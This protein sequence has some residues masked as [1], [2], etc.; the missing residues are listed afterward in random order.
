MST[1]N[2]PS[3]C[4]FETQAIRTQISRSSFNEHTTPLYLT[5]SFVF[6]HAEEMRAVFAEDV[7]KFSYTRFTHPNQTELV[8]KM[9]LLEKAEAGYTFSTGMAAIFGSIF[10][11]IKPGNHIV[12]CLNIFGSSRTIFSSI[13]P[14]WGV[15]TS[16]FNADSIDKLEDLIQPNTKILFVETPTNPSVDVLDLAYLGKIARKY[17][18]IFVVDNTFATPYLQNPIDFGADVVVHSTTKL[19]DGQ[20]RVCGGI[21]VGKT[22]L[23]QKIYL[24]SRTIGSSISAFDAWILS[25]S[26]ETL[27]VRVDRHCENALKVA[28]FLENH[29]KIESVRYPFLPSHP[30]FDIATKQMKA[31]GNIIAFKLK[32]D[33]QSA[34]NFIDNVKLFSRTANLG[35]SRTI[36]THPTTTTHAR[37]PQDEKLQTGI[38]DNLIRLSVG[39]ENVTDIIKDIHQAL[40]K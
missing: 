8:N 19:I 13:L 24:F 34:V 16:Y 12:S 36:V 26:L 3:D 1:S 18:L 28:L 7:D 31:G 25:K 14:D 10:P 22:D 21:A 37:I 35:D 32:G 9:C 23:I 39:L 30:Q 17:K 29:P 20:G 40:N 6:D 5:S 38:T 27:A 33:L 15:S 4:F 11:L 2:T